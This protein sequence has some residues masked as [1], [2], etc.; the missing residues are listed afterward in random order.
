MYTNTHG[1][2][3]KKEKMEEKI[4][5]WDNFSFYSVS[6]IGKGPKNS[7]SREKK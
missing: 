4:Q 6:L 5:K 2:V 1:R 7:M 3:S